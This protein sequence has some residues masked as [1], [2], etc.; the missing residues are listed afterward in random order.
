MGR[1]LEVVDCV[2]IGGIYVCVC[3]GGKTDMGEDGGQV[4]IVGR[5]PILKASVHP[6]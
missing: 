4:Y 6:S 2:E 3:G 5:G 1:W